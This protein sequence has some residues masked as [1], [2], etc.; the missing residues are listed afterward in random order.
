MSL[1]WDV[2][3]VEDWE[4]KNKADNG[5]LDILIWGDLTINMGG[6]PK[7]RVDVVNLRY[8]MLD[9]AGIYLIG[10]RKKRNP[11]LEDLQ[12]WEGLSTNVSYMSEK[13]F[14]SY[15]GRRLQTDAQ[16]RMNYA[17]RKAKEEAEET[18]EA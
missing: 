16:D 14:Q 12:K 8:R 13:K 7:G 5:L 6:V 10:N 2:S 1:N 9:A 17:L 3:T 11:S 4:G 18:S 15:L